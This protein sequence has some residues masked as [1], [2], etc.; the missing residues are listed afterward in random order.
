MNK[1]IAQITW[2]EQDFIDAFE[3]RFGSLPSEQELSNCLENFSAKQMEDKS[4]EFGWD[5]IY[6]AVEKSTASV[7]EI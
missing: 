3:E 6:D 1:I 2:T 4:T 5:F 7:C